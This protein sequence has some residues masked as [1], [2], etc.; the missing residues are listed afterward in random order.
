[1]LSRFGNVLKRRDS[2]IERKA[3][4]RYALSES[5]EFIHRHLTKRFGIN[6]HGACR[7]RLGVRD[8]QTI[9]NLLHR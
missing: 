9:I 1:M 7:L 8:I 3:L 6:V 5:Y 2:F 4:E